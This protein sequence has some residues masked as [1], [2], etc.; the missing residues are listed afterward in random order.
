MSAADLLVLAA[1]LLVSALVLTTVVALV[2]WF[3]RYD[4]EPLGLVAGAFAWGALAAPP[5]AVVLVGAVTMLWPALESLVPVLVGPPVEELLK[6]IAIVL[7]LVLSDQ[8]D[9]PT[10][11]LV[12][13]TAAGLGFAVTENTLHGMLGAVTGAPD[14][15]G[16]VVARTVSSSGIHVLTSSIVGGGIGFAVLA[17]SRIGR[18]AFP[19]AALTAAAALHASWNAVLLAPGRGWGSVPV[20]LPVLPALYA[21]W[22][23]VLVAFLR[24]EQGIL[25]DELGEEVRLGVLP[26]WV[27]EVI[28]S[29]RRRIRSDWWP[30]RRERTVI[31]RLMTR[32]A[33]RKHALRRM[34]MESKDLAGLEVV[35]LRRRLRRMLT[36]VTP[37]PDDD[38][39]PGA[40]P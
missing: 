34:P 26:A 11:G 28:P 5:L 37:G 3:D 14:T 27:V 7:V 21:A 10:D 31:A 17:R 1:S 38:P 13:G 32:L 22:L 35:H 19:V 8:F 9:N 36:P 40:S 30:R 16:L 33:F 2:W 24:G 20:W 23:G 4:R 18:I 29:Y 6:G 25:S 15:I 39:W 12:Y